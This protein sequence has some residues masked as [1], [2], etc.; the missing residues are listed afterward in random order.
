[1][2][3]EKVLRAPTS[4]DIDKTQL[5]H[6]TS[7]AFPEFPATDQPGSKRTY[8]GTPRAA[9]TRCAWGG[10]EPHGYQGRPWV[11]RQ[12]NHRGRNVSR[13][14]A[15]E[16]AGSLRSSG[17]AKG[18]GSRSA[19]RTIRR[20]HRTSWSANRNRKPNPA[21]R[22]GFCHPKACRGQGCFAQRKACSPGS[23]PL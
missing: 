7:D 15:S 9:N 3:R 8:N 4:D 10:T 17:R 19:S 1:M 2:T 20:I 18:G 11:H 22:R 5:P 12:R 14:P 21:I 6:L 16:G 23:W 13:M